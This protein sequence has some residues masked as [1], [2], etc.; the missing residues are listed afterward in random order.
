MKSN[1]QPL[2][3]EPKL[4]QRYV[5]SAV[6]VGI[7]LLTVPL[8]AGLPAEPFIFVMVLG[9]L[10]GGAILTARRSGPGGVRAL[11]SGLFRWRI[12]WRNWALAV[13]VMPA[14]TV[15]V[16]AATGTLISAPEGLL[17]TAV[18]Y[19][20]A[21]FLIGTLILNLWEETAWEGLVQRQL[22][23]RFGLAKGAFITAIPFAV[24][25]FPLSFAGG[26]SMRE[27]LIGTLLLVG[28]APPFRYLLGRT[29]YATG[30]SLL[31]V[32]VL[33]ASFNASGNLDVVSGDWQYIVGVAV[34]AAVA[35]VVD[36][37]RR[38]A[39]KRLSTEPQL[40]HP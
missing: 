21:T 6:I 7:V 39:V 4:L 23:G 29:D 30:G 38:A 24:I 28:M 13:V 19:L 14:A 34:V 15:A 11:F 18:D 25:H 35:V 40:V 16:A 33:H 22:M 36:L 2:K 31:A 27:A 20:V 5:I 8:I 12:G 1:P 17:T 9:P 37:R 10:L 32:G 26:A 3:V